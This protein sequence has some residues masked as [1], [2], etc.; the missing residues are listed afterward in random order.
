[1]PSPAVTRIFSFMI[2]CFSCGRLGR[3]SGSSLLQLFAG[4]GEAELLQPVAQRGAAGV[5]AE[6]QMRLGDADQAGVMIS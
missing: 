3:R 1:M 5:L 6:D 2:S 4:E